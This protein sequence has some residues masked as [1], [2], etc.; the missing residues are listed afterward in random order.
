MSCSSYVR[1]GFIMRTFLPFGSLIVSRGL[2]SCGDEIIPPPPGFQLPEGVGRRVRV[3][4][5]SARAPKAII[6]YPE[7]KTGKCEND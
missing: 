5:A 4:V 7:K 1:T 3:G 6:R 2:G